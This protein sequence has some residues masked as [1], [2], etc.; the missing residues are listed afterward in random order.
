[1]SG[2]KKVYA[3][4]LNLSGIKIKNM[5]EADSEILKH[6]VVISKTTEE[7]SMEEKFNGR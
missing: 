3:D 7:M 1:M 2:Y 4:T 5:Y 6:I